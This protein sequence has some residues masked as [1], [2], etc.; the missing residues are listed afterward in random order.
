VEA[1]SQTFHAP[2]ARRRHDARRDRRLKLA[3]YDTFRWAGEDPTELVEHVIAYLAAHEARAAVA[4]S[5]AER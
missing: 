3:G 4:G 5:P 2:R 1:D